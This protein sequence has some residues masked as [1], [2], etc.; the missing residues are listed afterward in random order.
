MKKPNLIPNTKKAAQPSEG[1]AVTVE[2]MIQEAHARLR[3]INADQ[4]KVGELLDVL[5]QE[6][7]EREKKLRESNQV[8]AD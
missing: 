6:I 8:I 2:G 5:Y 3:R 1:Q 4:S 7:V